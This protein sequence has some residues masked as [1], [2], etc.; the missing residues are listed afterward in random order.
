MSKLQ[1]FLWSTTR[2]DTQNVV[3][4]LVYNRTEH[5]ENPAARTIGMFRKRKRHDRQ[6]GA[7]TLQFDTS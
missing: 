6:R 2:L 3:I 7:P 4:L 1:E 5:Y